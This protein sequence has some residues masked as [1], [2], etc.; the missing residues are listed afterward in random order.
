MTFEPAYYRR[1]AIVVR[2]RA[3]TEP[4]AG[5]RNECLRLADY[6]ERL[7]AEIQAWAKLKYAPWLDIERRYRP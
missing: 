7:A 4:D 3:L 1:Q 6:F 5:R 2:T